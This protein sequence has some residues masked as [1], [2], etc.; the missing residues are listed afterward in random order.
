[1][2]WFMLLASTCW[3]MAGLI[4]LA[5][6]IERHHYD[7]HGKAAALPGA[8]RWRLQRFAGAACLLISLVCCAAYKGWTVGSTT[9]VA[10]FAV[11]AMLLM[12]MFS[13]CPGYVKNVLKASLGGGALIGLYGWLV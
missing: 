10:V 9:W 8:E 4:L 12:L 5:L 2:N 3:A 1:M 7:I 6:T 13:Y 11:A